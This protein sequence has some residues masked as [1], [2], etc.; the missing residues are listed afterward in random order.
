MKNSKY[1]DPK[2]FQICWSRRQHFAGW[3]GGDALSRWQQVLTE[4]WRP[5]WYYI[6]TRFVA[7]SHCYLVQICIYPEKALAGINCW[8]WTKKCSE[9][10]HF[11]PEQPRTLPEIAFHFWFRKI[12]FSS[13]HTKILFSY[14]GDWVGGLREGCGVLVS[15]WI[16]PCQW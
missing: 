5:T 8:F 6:N 2:N 12:C 10:R 9:R 15:N 7:Y 13:N 16:K 1:V 3:L 4:D 11:P 14:L